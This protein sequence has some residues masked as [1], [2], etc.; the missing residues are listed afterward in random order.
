VATVLSTEVWAWDA[1]REVAWNLLLALANLF[2]LGLLWAR[3]EKTSVGIGIFVF[4]CLVFAVNQ[5]V[6]WTTGFMIYSQQANLCLLGAA[7]TLV[8]APPHPRPFVIALLLTILG[9]FTSGYGLAAWGA[10]PLLLWLQGYRRWPYWVLWGGVALACALLYLRLSGIEVSHSGT[11][12]SYAAV[13]TGSLNL[14]GVMH[15]ALAYLG[16]LFT[17]TRLTWATLLGTLGLWLLGLNLWGLWRTQSQGQAW[18]VW[19]TL[20]AYT[21]AN[22][23][24]TALGRLKAYDEVYLGLALSTH[25]G[26]VRLLFWGGLIVLTVLNARAL[27]KLWLLNGLNLMIGLVLTA[28]FLHSNLV[29]LQRATLNTGALLGEKPRRIEGEQCLA[30]YPLT[31]QRACFDS[32]GRLNE[33]LEERVLQLAAF[34]LTLFADLEASNLLGTAYQEET[35]VLI[36]TPSPWLNVYASLKPISSTSPRPRVFSH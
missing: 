18:G 19:L 29:M 30:A 31:R 28:F 36:A 24:V 9:T 23:L 2:L 35:P 14:L 22:S 26:S 21:L 25:Y 12:T 13:E 34:R 5:D 17:A 4:A 20:M 10:L 7:V 1:E 33:N 8:H 6:N 32:V 16:G 15:F 11:N 3:S 27:P